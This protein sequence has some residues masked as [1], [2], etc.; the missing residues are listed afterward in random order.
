VKKHSIEEAVEKILV[1]EAVGNRELIKA[2][3]SLINVIKMA[4]YQDV[5]LQKADKFTSSKEN[6]VFAAFGT[7]EGFVDIDFYTTMDDPFDPK[8]E[9]KI[10]SMKNG[11]R[12]VRGL[13]YVLGG[14]SKITKSTAVQKAIKD[15][16]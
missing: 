13:P 10:D 7:S 4:G 3:S 2:A 11:T 15:N 5:E 9:I 12:M 14:F 8:I 16:A 1:G 6:G